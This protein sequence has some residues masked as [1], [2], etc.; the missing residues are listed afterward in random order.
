MALQKKSF[1]GK[2]VA[3]RKAPAAKAARMVTSAALK[4]AESLPLELEEGETPFL[5]LPLSA[6]S[7]FRHILSLTTLSPQVRCP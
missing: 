2:A 6:H 5:A 7:L 3:V 4:V 1:N